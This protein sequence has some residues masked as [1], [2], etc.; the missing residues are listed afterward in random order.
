MKLPKAL[1]ATKRLKP[2]PYTEEMVKLRKLFLRAEQDLI[3]IIGYKKERGQV[4][5]SHGAQ[6][7]RVQK[8]LQTFIDDSWKYVPNLVEEQYLMGKQHQLGYKKAVALTTIG[9]GKRTIWIAKQSIFA[10]IGISTIGMVLAAFG[11]IPPVV[12]VLIQEGVDIAVI[13]NALRAS[14]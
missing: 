10:G 4:I 8:T 7:E 3:N 2:V 12:G 9:I 6:L 14:R 1:K 13:I 11:H 5:Y